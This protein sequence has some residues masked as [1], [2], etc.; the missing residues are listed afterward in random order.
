MLKN[1]VRREMFRK[2]EKR[3][4]IYA[5][6][7]TTNCKP[8]KVDTKRHEKA[9]KSGQIDRLI[10]AKGLKKYLLTTLKNLRKDRKMREYFLCIYLAVFLFTYTFYNSCVLSFVLSFSVLFCGKM[11][12]KD[13]ER[14]RGETL[15]LQ[16]KDVLYSFSAS[17]A[18]G[19]QLEEAV[20]D[21]VE[22]LGMV[23]QG[24]SPMLTE[25]GILEKN[26]CQNGADECSA[27]REFA[28][29]CGVEDIS[30]FAEVFVI[31]RETGGDI[32][33]VIEKTAR[34]LIDKITIEREIQVYMSQK[35]LEGKIIFVMPLIVILGLQ[36]LS[37]EYIGVLYAGIKG[38]MIM[39]VAMAGMIISGVLIKRISDIRI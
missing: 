24:D 13:K 15:K 12:Q 3:H 27:L 20:G 6:D 18:C 28:S 5:S 37:P 7:K 1:A 17:F 38:R 26:M 4:K 25:L 29:R 39:T 14:K 34:V 22:N 23:Y 30:G 32:Q 31:C 9:Q 21:A 10:T 16:F 36:F 11:Y 33:K 35:K 8:P 2:N 19:R